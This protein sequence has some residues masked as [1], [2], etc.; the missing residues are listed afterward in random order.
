M[1]E[2]KVALIG[3]GGIGH[4][5]HSAYASLAKEGAPIKLVAMCDVN[6]EKFSK[7]VAINIGTSENAVTNDIALFTDVDELIAKADFDMAD[8][9]LPTYMHKEMTCKLLKADKHVLCE[10][11][12][13]LCSDECAEMLKA[14]KETG[15]KL[16]IGQCLR[17]SPEYLYLKEC[18]NTGKFG[19]LRTLVMDRLSNYPTWGFEDWFGSTEKSGG[20]ILDLHV[21]DIDAVRFI[22][23]DPM[24]VSVISY[25]GRTRWQ[26]NNTRLFYDGLNVIVNGSWDEAAN[27]PFKAGYRARFEKA[28]VIL[29]GSAVTVYPEEGGREAVELPKKDMYTE[30]IRFFA[31]SILDDS[32]ESNNTPEDTL[33]TVKLVETMRRSAELDGERVAFN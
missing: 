3:F 5:H 32:L 23:G 6:E 4:T 27:V 17:F 2:V 26:Y 19:K 13:A 10:K 11:P 28:S 25:N 15:K 8:I 20:C 1:N 30:E 18:V 16:M 22:L 14:S 29:E 9:C 7:G 24:S 12:M 31:G 33:K 21:H